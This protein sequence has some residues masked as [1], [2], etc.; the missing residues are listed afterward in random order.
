MPLPPYTGPNLS[1]GSFPS[2]PQTLSSLRLLSLAEPFPTFHKHLHTS[3]VSQPPC[4]LH[5]GQSK[6]V[7]P[8]HPSG[9]EKGSHLPHSIHTDSDP[10]GLLSGPSY[11]GTQLQLSTLMFLPESPCLQTSI[12]LGEPPPRPP[13]LLPPTQLVWRT[14]PNRDQCTPGLL[15]NGRFPSLHPAGSSPPRGL[16]V[17]QQSHPFCFGEFGG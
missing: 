7:L 1:L 16:Q 2:W 4:P 10:S 12:L 5:G 6:H 13:A 3:A 9:K 11:C 17:G 15:H 14:S 8:T